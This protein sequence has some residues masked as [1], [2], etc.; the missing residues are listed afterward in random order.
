MMKRIWI[1][2]AV[3]LLVL[4]GCAQEPLLED[5][6]DGTPAETAPQVTEKSCALALVAEYPGLEES[7]Y[8]RAAWSGLEKAA[9]KKNVTA[10]CYHPTEISNAAGLAAINEAVENG[11][12]LV[13]CAGDSYAD[14]VY[15]A[16]YLYPQVSFIALECA[17]VSA[18]NGDDTIEDNVYAVYY[19]EEQAGFLAGYAAVQEGY[20]KLGFLGG[21]AVPA[22]V[23]YGAGYLQGVNY[24][25]EALRVPVEV[26]Y[27]YCGLFYDDP[28]VQ[29]EAGFWFINGT[30]LI[31]SSNIAFTPSL[32]A[33][34]ESAGTMLIGVDA[35]HASESET[36]LTSVKKDL[37]GTVYR[38]ALDFFAGE[39]TGG[40]VAYLGA[41]EG[42]ISLER[43]NDRFNK[44]TDAQYDAIIGSL[45]DGTVVVRPVED[46]TVPLQKLVGSYVT[47]LYEEKK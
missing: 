37:A 7:A 36:M 39:F 12:Q 15:Q 3:C 2:L 44:L 43:V 8:S 35:D 4:A 5:A 16:Q 21:M 14:A 32:I 17:P 19:R 10:R 30:Q 26:R 20:T 11:A 45:A 9:K 6:A 34:A 28:A 27:D 13:V 22:A 46:I 40:R 29:T 33:A 47:I 18:E 24:A 41:A 1:L 25:A 23:R 38:A 42:G 31:F